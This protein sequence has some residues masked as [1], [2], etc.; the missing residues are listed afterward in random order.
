MQLNICHLYEGYREILDAYLS[1]EGPEPH[2][3]P[4][5]VIDVAPWAETIAAMPD[6]Q[7]MRLDII[8]SIDRAREHIGRAREYIYLMDERGRALA[9]DLE[10]R[11]REKLGAHGRGAD[12][13]VTVK[14]VGT[15]ERVYHGRPW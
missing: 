11:L 13:V 15:N 10:R 9:S 3:G 12:V 4:M 5:P 8:M 14:F 1:F 2:D 7:T 6:I